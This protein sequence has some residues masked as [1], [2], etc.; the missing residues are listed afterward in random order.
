[1]GR[2]SKSNLGKEN[3]LRNGASRPAQPQ[4]KRHSARDERETPRLGLHMLPG[5]LVTDV[6]VVGDKWYDVAP[7][8]PAPGEE[9]ETADNK[10]FSLDE[11]V[12][13][14]SDALQAAS[15][16]YE[17]KAGSSDEARR[18]ALGREKTV[19]DKIAAVTLMV[20]E[21]PVHRLDELHT[22][23]GYAQKKGRRERGPA[24]DALKDLFLSDLLPDTRRLISIERRNYAV[25]RTQ[26]TKRHLAYAKFESEL[27]LVYRSFL[28]LVDEIGKDSVVHFR[29]KSA[30]IS[31]DLL[32]SKP[33]NEQLLLSM[34]V[35]ELGAPDRKVASTASYYLVQLTTKHH[36]AMRLVVVQEVERLIY[37]PNISM[38]GRYYAVSFLNQIRFV[39][40]QDVTLARRLV[41]IYMDLFS[42]GVTEDRTAKHKDGAGGSK[43]QESRLMGALLS[44]V[45][46]AFPYSKPETDDTDY[47]AQLESLFKVAH[48]E[49]LSSATKALSFLFQV[50]QSNEGVSDRFYRALYSRIPDAGQAAE[51]KQALFLNLVYRSMKVD[52]SAKRLKAYAKRLLQ[53]SLQSSPGFAAGSLL[54]LSEIAVKQRK[55]LLTSMV[56]FSEGGDADEHFVDADLADTPA[57]A[58]KT[59]GE[60]SADAP[61][62]P[63]RNDTA[64]ITGSQA[65]RAEPN[66]TPQPRASVT[67]GSGY[68]PD[69]RDPQ[70]AGAESS[71]LWELVA[72]SYHH[73]PSVVSFATKLCSSASSISYN[74]DPLSDFGLGPFLDKFCYR[75]P[76]RHVVD[77][78]HGRRSARLVVRPMVN[79]AEF[80]QMGR[81]GEVEEDEKFYVRFFDANPS[82]VARQGSDAAGEPSADVTHDDAQ[83]D[84]SSEEEAFE[85]ALRE[86]MKRLGGGD[87]LDDDGGDIDAV[88]EDELRAFEEAFKDEMGGDDD[89]EGAT[90]ENSAPVLSNGGLTMDEEHD[91]SPSTSEDEALTPRRGTKRKAL[92]KASAGSPFAPVEDYEAM[93]GTLQG[94]SDSESTDMAG[95]KPGGGPKERSAKR[96]RSSA[97]EGR[98]RKQGGRRRGRKRVPGQRK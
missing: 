47:D 21:S 67:W 63:S 31:F 13:V 28:E 94:D 98:A 61:D 5:E 38:R 97:A 62:A 29:M 16:A 2:K 90:D 46:R 77:S 27:R 18:K 72:L 14:A 33:E 35:N 65:S 95:E 39:S 56:Q 4:A 60:T 3:H 96:L 53:V 32:A 43:M 44:G 80:L 55:G 45:N 49:S 69:K 58:E 91:S 64:K 12:S 85:T 7:E 73:H 84:A 40:D 57:P 10:L 93:L 9:P 70:F 89:G 11:W 54:V 51:S 87:M 79:T 19:T 17:R 66:P 88:D 75:K 8:W 82:R 37:R 6:D 20:Q 52:V 59:G 23:M 42:E 50:A 68:H 24:M 78:L 36:P 83:S 41:K 1:M 74:G 71:C 30:R 92:L 81:T 76:K 34:L 15:R 86:E 26:L 48:A 25:K 22:L